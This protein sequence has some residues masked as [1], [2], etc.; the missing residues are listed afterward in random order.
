MS[1]YEA[2]IDAIRR[3]GAAAV[4]AG[5]QDRGVDLAGPLS[6]MGSALPGSR[7]A[8]AAAGVSTGWAQ[9][10]QDWSRDSQ[11]Y[12]ENLVKPA[13]LYVASDQAAEAHLGQRPAFE[14]GEDRNPRPSLITWRTRRT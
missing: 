8:H 11:G 5:D 3:A 1:G 2:A 13:D 4:S 6:G 7:S 12:G 10:V 14:P 9:R